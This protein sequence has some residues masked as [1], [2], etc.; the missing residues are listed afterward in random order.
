MARAIV[1]ITDSW[2][3][4][5][6]GEAVFTI[7][8]MAKASE[9]ILNTAQSETAA[10]RINTAKIGKQVQQTSA[11]TTYAKATVATGCEILVDDD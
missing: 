11:V 8:K 9:I 10:M 3:A 1:A 7:Q 4:I 2:Q 6:T 5:A